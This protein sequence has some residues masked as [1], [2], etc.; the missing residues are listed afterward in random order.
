MNNKMIGIL[1][2]MGPRSTS[3][4]LELVL[5][6]CQ[7][8]YGA[9]NDIDYP[10]IMIYSLPTPFFVGDDIDD[11]KLEKSIIEG[12]IKL[13]NC[14]ID[15]MAIPCNTAHKYINTINEAVSAPVLNMIELT[16]NS[17]PNNSIVTVM[18]TETTMNT[19][20][21]QEGIVSRGSTYFF[22]EEWQ[23][24]VNSIISLVKDNKI[25]EA[26]RL[27][28]KLMRDVI[29]SNVGVV[30]IA[31]TDI[32]LLI[33]DSNPITY[34]DSSQVLAQEIIKRYI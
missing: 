4:F 11:E 7:E 32:S 3:P 9:T 20:L 16:I 12:A 29:E 1:A 19:Q 15:Y 13:D 30:I 22:K 18:G 27:Y 23:S 8:Q 14:G 17:I 10:H 33:N 25:S 21:Y 31:C 28:E 26:K 5:N 6:Q 24:I 2:G 34:I